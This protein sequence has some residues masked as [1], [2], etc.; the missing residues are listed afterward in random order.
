MSNFIPNTVSAERKPVDIVTGTYVDYAGVTRA[1]SV[2]ARRREAFERNGL[3][4]ALVWVVFGADNSFAENE[5]FNVSG[6]LRLHL[7]TSALRPYDQRVLWGPTNLTNQ[8]GT[9][10]EYDP[11]TKLINAERR[12]ASLGYSA[13]FGFEFE[14]LLL[15]AEVATARTSEGLQQTPWQGCGSQTFLERDAFFADLVAAADNAGIDIEQL[16]T[17]WDTNQFE[18]STAPDTP[19]AAADKTVLFKLLLKR[20]AAQHGLVAVLSP[21]PFVD[22]PGNGGHVHFSL[23]NLEDDTSLLSGGNG[24]H[25][26]TDEGDSA[27]AGVQAH[28]ADLTAIL[29]GSPVSLLRLQ[30]ETWTGAAVSWGLENREAAIRFIENNI[31][32]PH[33]ANIEVKNRDSAAN[34][35]LSLA[36]I[37]FSALDGIEKKLPLPVENTQYP[38]DYS[39]EEKKERGIVPFPSTYHGI[40]E[41]FGKSEAVRNLPFPDRGICRTCASRGPAVHSVYAHT[42]SIAEFNEA[43]FLDGGAWELAVN[44]MDSQL[45]FALLHDCAPPE[46]FIDAYRRRLREVAASAAGFKSIAAYRTGF[47]IDWLGVTEQDVIRAVRNLSAAEVSRQTNPIIEAFAVRQAV[48]LGLPMQFHVGVGDADT[49]L[50]TCNPAHLVPL[51]RYAKDHGTAVV[52]LHCVPYERE[53]AFLCSVHANVYMDVSLA[54]PHMGA[55]VREVLRNVLAW[56]P[57]DKLLYASDGIGISE[58]HYLAAVLFRRYIARIA[59]DWVSDG[60]WNANQAKRVIDAIAHANA[61]RLYGLA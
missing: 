59:I 53:A 19:V 61:E 28:L 1:K 22:Q 11:R 29:A 15:P 21:K 40:T 51:I 14:V 52:L 25:G 38:G 35:Y 18:V 58:L 24:P 43:V 55:Q 54:N 12:A 3:G 34:L 5:K 13:L 46:R 36:G 27:I 48:V 32:N 26:L 50:A 41:A 39:E 47:A 20:V 10:S 31:G 42:P 17:E 6:D 60:A 33:G 49:E 57:F 56:C 2:P 30:P 44:R 37:L 45:G 9:V 16:H 23:S 4:A 7:D 8:D